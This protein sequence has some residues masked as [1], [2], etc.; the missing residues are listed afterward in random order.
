[1]ALLTRKPEDKRCMDT[2][3]EFCEALAA[4]CAFSD[5]TLVPIVIAILKLLHVRTGFAGVKTNP[6]LA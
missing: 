6:M 1:L 5:I 2:A 3:R 4:R